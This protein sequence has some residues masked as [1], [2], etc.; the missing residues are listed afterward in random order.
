[1]DSAPGVELEQSAPSVASPPL[2]WVEGP[3]LKVSRFQPVFC[4]QKVFRF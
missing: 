3:L 1:M 4:F 2:G